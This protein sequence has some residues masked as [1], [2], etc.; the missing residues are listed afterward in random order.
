[1]NK[2]ATLLRVS[3]TARFLI[4]V[5]VI[6]IATGIIFFGITKQS[7]NFI[8]TEAVATKVEIEPKTDTNSADTYTVYFKYTVNGKEY[9]EGLS[10][11]GKTTEGEKMKIYYD[12]ADPRVITN[13]KSMIFPLIFLAAGVAALAGGIVSAVNAVKRINK[14]KAQEREWA[15]GQ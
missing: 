3:R 15:N 9:N 11:M 13:S 1:M 5:G 2:I 14:M 12:P 8:E 7:Q 4:P 10:G 6:L